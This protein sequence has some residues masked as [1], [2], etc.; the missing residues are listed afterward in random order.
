MSKESEL[1]GMVRVH[2]AGGHRD[3]RRVITDMPIGYLHGQEIAVV[4]FIDVLDTSG[5]PLGQHFH[6]N[7]GEYFTIAKGKGTLIIRAVMPGETNRIKPEIVVPESIAQCSKYQGLFGVETTLDVDSS[8]PNRKFVK[9][10]PGLA[11]TF[12]LSS[13]SVLVPFIVDA[14]NDFNPHDKGNYISFPLI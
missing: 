4:N 3:S 11:H 13:G 6:A 7:Y 12:I 10:S 5:L 1:E 8:D 2:P 14:P 9:V